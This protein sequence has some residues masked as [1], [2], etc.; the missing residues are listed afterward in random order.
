MDIIK[1]QNG[2]FEFICFAT[3][4]ETGE[5]LLLYRDESGNRASPCKEYHNLNH[6][7]R[8]RVEHKSRN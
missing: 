1:D 2:P 6:G 8:F 5:M 3:H 4:T 7:E